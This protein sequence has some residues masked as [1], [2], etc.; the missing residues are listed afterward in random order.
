MSDVIFPVVVDVLLGD[1]EMFAVS[2]SRVIW[3]TQSIALLR[4]GKANKH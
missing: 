3:S 4:F 2:Q 1:R